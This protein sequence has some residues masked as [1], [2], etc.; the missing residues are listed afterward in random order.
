M[1]YNLEMI[2]MIKNNKLK[3]KSN[4]LRIFNSD[5][6]CKDENGKENSICKI[7]IAGKFTY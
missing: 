1:K 2:I 4:K 3:I 7:S 6:I 5:N